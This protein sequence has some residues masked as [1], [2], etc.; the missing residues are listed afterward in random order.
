MKLGRQTIKTEKDVKIISSATVAGTKEQEGRLK[1]RFD[2]L[3][4]DGYYNEKTWEKA[5]TKMQFEAA[6]AAVSKAGISLD[7]ID[8]SFAGD[9]LNQCTATGYCFRGLNVPF[10]GLYGAC[11]TMAL[12]LSMGM[13]AVGGG[14][15]KNALCGTSS[16]F[17]SSEK[18]FRMPLAY[19]GQR[20][21][22]A[23]RTVTG[24]GMT[25]LSPEGTGPV[26][27]EATIG[28]ITDK[29]IKDGMNMGAAM[30]PAAADTIMAHFKDTGKSPDFYDLIVTGD[31]G[32]LGYE[33]TCDIL[34]KNGFK[35]NNYNDC[36]IMIFDSKKQDTHC[37][38]SGCGCSA[39]VLCAYIL[40]EMS[41]GSI[42]NVLF[43]GT[44]ALMSPLTTQ[45]GESIPA[46]AHAVAISNGR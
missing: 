45:Q 2:I 30:A 15:A 34:K 12:S 18:Q 17:C 11:S 36:G 24:S 26:V 7:D 13:M 29:G 19:G 10:C 32:E 8:I 33:I 37:G 35:T 40:D 43:V 22:T 6:N 9:L 42:N 44:G 3:M 31:L 39:L 21:P 25:V 23:Q 16:H 27:T 4:D 28:K 41:K 46:I 14:F 38:G 1:G 20:P 5:E